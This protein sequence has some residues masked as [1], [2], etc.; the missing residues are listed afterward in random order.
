MGFDS[1]LMGTES[2]EQQRAERISLDW[3]QAGSITGSRP[4]L[5]LWAAQF[6]ATT[7]VYG[8]GLAGIVLVEERA[9]SSAW[10]A[11][12]LACSIFPAFVGSLVAGA[13]VDRVGRVPVMSACHLA[14]ALLGLAFWAAGI[15]LGAPLDLL[16]ILAVTA[17]VAF[18]TQFTMT[19]ELALVPDL[20][21][22][23]RRIPANALLQIGMLVGEGLGIIVLA[24][25]VIQVAGV[26]GVGLLAALLSLVA[27]ALVLGLPRRQLGTQHPPAMER[28]WARLGSEVQAGWQTMVQDR[29]L[30]SVALELTLAATLLLML[31][32]LFPG[33]LSRHLGLGAQSAPLLL[34]P[35]G[36]GFLL[37]AA[38]LSH[39]SQ[40]NSRLWWTGIGLLS[41][42]ACV[43]LLA[44]LSGQH[45]RL[46]A[47]LPVV[48]AMGLSFALVI[49]PAR[50]VLQ[51][52]PPAEM[53]GRVIA[54]Q[55]VLA[56]AAGLI[57]LL[58]GGAAADRVGIRTVMTLLGLLAF[59]A[60][61]LG[62]RH[63]KLA[64]GLEPSA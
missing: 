5:R 28:N 59:G 32:S 30:L 63:A 43:V 15:L 46:L 6:I 41:L 64:A 35:G 21:E 60:G 56:H 2:R 38:L 7:A 16:A 58:L 47:I 20:V 3:S 45:G 49:V 10:T 36:L 18:S 55:L 17:L 51:E 50:T 61:A 1:R 48:G 34:L 42:G 26:P 53:R 54:T 31:V 37:G 19:A 39:W 13:V 8:L 9:R 57:P 14:R 11:V 62:L 44:A 22:A 12:A 27:L 52:R 4:F 33:L 29:V 23:E 25:V 24:P 40:A